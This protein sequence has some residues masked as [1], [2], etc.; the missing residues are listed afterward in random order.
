MTTIY[1]IRHAQGVGNYNKTF[2]GHSDEHLSDMGEKQILGLAERFK[3]KPIDK[4]YCSTLLRAFNTSSAINKYHDLPII[5]LNGLK[6]INGGGFE[7]KTWEEIE[8][9]YPNEFDIWQNN[10]GD[11]VAPDGESMKQV[12]DRMKDTI[13]KIA[14]KNKNRKIVIVSHGCA[15]LNFLSYLKGNDK[16]ILDEYRFGTH[17]GVTK[18]EFDENNKGKII[19]RNSTSHLEIPIEKGEI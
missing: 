14:E 3:A 8:T 4:I 15:I 11:F 13:L 10:L 18:I 1:L 2:Q 17:S 19:Y 5:A 7:G 6:E 9:E 12:Y 16:L